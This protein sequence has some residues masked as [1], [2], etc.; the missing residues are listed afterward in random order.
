MT[1][2]QLG[3][4]SQKTRIKEAKEYL[5][6]NPDNTIVSVAERFELQ[7]TTLYNSISRAKN[8]VSGLKKKHGGHNKI[9][10]DHE[11]ERIH[12]FI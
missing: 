8:P 12:Y 1:S 9:F 5:K 6:A 10:E 3:D 11:A 7:K 2:N 4:K